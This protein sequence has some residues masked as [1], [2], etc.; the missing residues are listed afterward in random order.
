VF[1]GVLFAAAL[2]SA[3]DAP[4]AS[5]DVAPVHV[6]FR[7]FD[8]VT[9]ITSATTVRVRH[10]GTRERG[11]VLESRDLSVDLLP[12]IYDAEAMCQ[13]PGDTRAI[14]LADHLV[15]MAYP[16]EG[17]RHIEVINFASGFGALELRWTDAPPADIAATAITVSKIGGA[18]A[19]A[20]RAARG[21]GY[22]LLVVPADTYD[23]R[24][25]RPGHEPILLSGLEIPAG[26]T[27]L[28]VVR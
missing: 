14:R 26:A 2:V 21:S 12:G 24:V 23:V 28:K 10:S 16:D 17:G 20:V 18:H 8:G 7:V 1:D 6:E 25:T 3:L 9:E 19:T 15:V 22:L 11:T 5:N 4:Q 13:K 27:R